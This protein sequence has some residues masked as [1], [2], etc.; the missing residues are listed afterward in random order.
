MKYVVLIYS[1]PAVWE[2]M[3]PEERDRAL[4]VHFRLIEELTASGELLRVDGLTHPSTTKTI[5]RSAGVPAVT[6]GPFGEAKEQ[7]AGL[8]ALDVE[9]LERALEIATPLTE[10][11]VVEVRE[12]MDLGG[13]E[14]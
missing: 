1:N 9:S 11:D 6:D 8:W 14:M 7:L 5:R 3:A 12:L 2:A 10:Y 4:G 13:S